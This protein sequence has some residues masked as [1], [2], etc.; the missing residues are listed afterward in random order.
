[1][2]NF[3]LDTDFS[4]CHSDPNVYTKKVGIHLIILFLYVDDLILTGSDPKLLNHVKTNLKKKFEMT[5]LGYLHYF[6]GLQVL[7]T[8]EGIFLSQS[9]YACDLLHAFT[10]M[11][12]NQ[13]LLPS[14]L[15]SNLLPLVLLLKLM[16]LCTIS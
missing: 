11:I 6:L 5:D 1:M 8:K 7:Q 10:W 4:R 2:D 3:L 15:E 14:S 12:L 9:K 13:P 16:P